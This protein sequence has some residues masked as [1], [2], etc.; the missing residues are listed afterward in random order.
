MGLGTKALFAKR[1]AKEQYVPPGSEMTGFTRRPIFRNP[2]FVSPT[3]D[4]LTPVSKK[5][6]AAKKKH[7]DKCVALFK[8]SPRSLAQFKPSEESPS[9]WVVC[10]RPK[11]H[12]HKIMTM[13]A[14]TVKQLRRRTP[15]EPTPLRTQT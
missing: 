10:S 4:M 7:F 9:R 3:D 2:N 8:I 15:L 1:M 12:R 6:N 11:S 5:L 13:S 14:M